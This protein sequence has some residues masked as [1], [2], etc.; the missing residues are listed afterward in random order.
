MENESAV[1]G[2]AIADDNTTTQLDDNPQVD[3][4]GDLGE[5]KASNYE[6]GPEKPK[7]KNSE[8]PYAYANNGDTFTSESFKI[9]IMNL[10]KFCGFKVINKEVRFE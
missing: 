7:E 6:N 8:D 9:E 1:M 10:P 2:E 5:G 4:S 3:I